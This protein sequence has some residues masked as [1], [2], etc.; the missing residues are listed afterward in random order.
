[1]EKKYVCFRIG[2]VSNNKV[3][4][5]INHDMRIGWQPKYINHALMEQNKLIYGSKMDKDSYYSLKKEQ[6]TRSKRKIQKNTERFFSGIFTFSSTLKEDYKNN[7][8]LFEKCSKLFCE[9]LEK[10]YGFQINYAQLHV[11]EE[12]P[13]IHLMFDNISKETGKAIRRKI[14]PEI[15][16]KCQ[17]LMGDCFKEF[18]YERGEENSK[19]FHLN[20]KQL[21]EIDSARKILENDLENYQNELKIFDKILENEKLT[22]N[23][24]EVL[25][26]LAPSLFQFIENSNPKKK[27]AL[28]NNISKVITGNQKL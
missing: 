9:E 6:D 26:T 5:E 23:E 22:E 13:H 11:D 16:F 17:T 8:K 24:I 25:Q 10:Q 1:M 15:L 27:Q 3:L 14:N 18:G 21:H 12:N 20:V 7:P 19:R 28:S 4:S 2:K